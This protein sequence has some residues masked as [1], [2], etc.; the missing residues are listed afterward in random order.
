MNN[1]VLYKIIFLSGFLALATATSAQKPAIDLIPSSHQ[2]MHPDASID[3][4]LVLDSLVR[5]KAYVQPPAKNT[6]KAPIE[7]VKKVRRQIGP[8]MDSLFKRTEKKEM[9]STRKAGSLSLYIRK[10]NPVKF[11][12]SITALK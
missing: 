5:M 11:F 8:S 10:F 3:T 6:E 2:I 1:I 12:I 9:Q 4:S 7:N